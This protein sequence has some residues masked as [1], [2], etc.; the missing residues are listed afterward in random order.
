MSTGEHD[1]DTTGTAEQNDAPAKPKL[2]LDVQISDVGPCKKHIKV[3]ISRED[4]DR[5]F[6]ESLGSITREAHVPGFRPGHAPKGLVEKRF[7]K[8]VVGQVKSSLLMSSLEQLDADYK[9]NPISQPDLDID[10]I[11][12]PENSPLTF[13]M[14]V[15]VRPEFDLPEYK[16]LKV[17]RPTRT[18]SDAD[19]ES[20]IKT[21]LERYAQIVPKLEGGAVQGDFLVADIQFLLAGVVINEA[22]EA[23]FRV[24]PE[25]RFQD[26]TI[27][28]AGQ[29][30][31]GVKA[32]ETRT[33]QAKIG[34]SSPDPSL[35]GQTVD[36]N[37]LV[38][39]VK[40]LRMP[41]I[42]DEFVQQTGFRTLDELKTVMKDVLERR[43]VSQ[44]QEQVRRDV[45]DQLLSKAPF[46]LP[47]DLVKREERTTIR[48]LVDNLR[49][50]G[51]SGAD[52][53]AR[54]AEIRANAHERTLRS[55]KEFFL[56][57]KVAEAEDLTVD[58]D[59]MELEIERL[60]ERND[61]S[62]R[63]IRARIEKE[64]LAD[65]LAT[66]ILERKALDKVLE[67]VEFEDVAHVEE[68]QVETLDQTVASASAAA[69]AEETPES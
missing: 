9:L 13:E 57:S 67:Y 47:A 65:T 69:D 54:E 43:A 20:Q 4:V 24:F 32:G 17:K 19:V 41:E 3:T 2:A 6:Q 27:P 59:D 45:M 58:D 36:V 30:L 39:D 14:D 15:E 18:I 23:Q 10:S 62:P 21:F 8:Q 25:L 40:F 44:S 46:D 38:H 29:I 61:E 64:G 49:Q 52:I 66:Q 28:N 34:D 31:E 53:R 7:R 60:A 1:V 37:F 51:L 42:N 55:L 16:G 56:L 22:K 5:Q 26:G 50:S 12:L 48:R 63:R 68:A 11:E 35:R 33:G